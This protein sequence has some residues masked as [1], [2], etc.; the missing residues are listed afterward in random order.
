ML[1]PNVS[2]IY[3]TCSDTTA[4]MH[5]SM[6]AVLDD[7]SRLT[8]GQRA[9]PENVDRKIAP[10]A[11]HRGYKTCSEINGMMSPLKPN[12]LSNPYPSGRVYVKFRAVGWYFSFYSNFNRTFCLQKVNTLIRRRV[13]RRL[14]WV[15]TVCLC[16]IKW[17]PGLYGLTFK[18]MI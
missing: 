15:C 17:T 8:F 5:I 14:I 1:L 9:M 11:H 13:L 7:I 12:G 3:A 10:T 4:R 6:D 18:L 2:P 16:S